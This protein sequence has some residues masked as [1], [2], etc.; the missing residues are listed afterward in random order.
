MQ[1]EAIHQKTGV[2]LFDAD[3]NRPIALLTHHQVKLLVTLAKIG[4]VTRARL[5]EAL[6]PTARDRAALSQT[7]ARLVQAN[8]VEETAA[9]PRRDQRQI[10][11]TTFGQQ[12]T[13]WLT[14]EW[15]GWSDYS[16]LNRIQRR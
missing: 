2:L 4:T 6:R 7:L 10:K 12:V 14:S 9:G 13:T 1:L 3:A 15:R 11:L 16:R 5:L 8:L